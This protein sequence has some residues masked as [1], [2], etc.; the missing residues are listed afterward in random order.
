VIRPRTTTSSSSDDGF[1]LVEMLVAIVLSTVLAGILLVVVL[2][3][4][5]SANN[6][7]QSADLTAEARGALNRMSADLGQA[8]PL[9][10]SSGATTTTLPA[11]TAAANPDGPSYDANQV[12]SVTFNLDANG[13]GCVTGIASNNVS[14]VTSPAPPACT[15]GGTSD[16]TNPET[17]TFCWIPPGRPG[18]G[19]LYL[20]E[21]SPSVEQTPV[22]NCGS[23]TPL[24]AGKVTGFE[25]SYRSSLYLY[26]NISHQDPQAGI[27]TWYDLDTAGPPVG[28]SDGSLDLNELQ[29]IDSVVISLHMSEGGHTE[30]FQTQVA[31][32]NVHPND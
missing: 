28:N 32:R 18:G 14:P 25:L 9:T 29:K 12:T 6:T 30:S 27:T 15:T 23:G 26:Q 4:E 5:H 21:T 22:T 31:V 20:L 13:D 1:T 8:V 16:P 2:N 10:I 7:T 19:E 3:S 11:L 17:E 24:L